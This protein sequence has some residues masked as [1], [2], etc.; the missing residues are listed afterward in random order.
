MDSIIQD[1]FKVSHRLHVC[2]PKLKKGNLSNIEFLML[3]GI[4]H[5]LKKKK[6][7]FLT[8]QDSLELCGEKALKK[9]GVT[10]RELTEL[11]GMSMSAASKKISILENKGLLQR[12]NS[13][14]DRRNV[15]ITLTEE[16]AALCAEEEEKKRE[17]MSEVIRRMGAEDARKLI[18]L[19]N[20]MF[21]IV[22]QMELEDAGEK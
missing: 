4:S 6:G 15:Y 18:D 2:S 22:E 17:W 20:H 11:M 10:L 3:V 13:K 1:F 8:D 19:L 7:G 9:N 5:I 21:D 12:E 16:G 14:M